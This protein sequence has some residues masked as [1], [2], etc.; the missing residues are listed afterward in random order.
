MEELGNIIVLNREALLTSP[1]DNGSFIR[2]TETGFI[3]HGFSRFKKLKRVPHDQARIAFEPN[4]II[5]YRL[6]ADDEEEPIPLF[7]VANLEEI[8]QIEAWLSHVKQIRA[9]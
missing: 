3:L 1:T 6:L 9:L 4:Q 7:E 5:L 8:P 2:V